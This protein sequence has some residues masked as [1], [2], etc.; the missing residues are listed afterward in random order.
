MDAFDLRLWQGFQAA[1]GN[2]AYSAIIDQITIDSRRIDSAHALFV[3]LKGEKQDGHVYVSQARAMGAKYALISKEWHPSQD[4]TPLILLRVDNPLKAFQEI[5][6]CYRNQLSSSIIGIT[7]SFGKT[8]VKDLLLSLLGT[9]KSAAASPESFNSQ[10]GVPLSLLTLRKEHQVAIIE[11]GISQRQEIDALVEIIRPDHVL[12]TPIGKKH[13]ATLEDIPTI[14][15]EMSK[16]VQRASKKG[17]KLLPDD[18][19]LSSHLNLPQESFYVWEHNSHP[20]PHASLTSHQNSYQI[21]FPDGDYFQGRIT[22]G[23]SYFLNLINMAIKAAWLEGVSSSN[24]K[25]VLADYRPE[26]TR[27][28]IWKSSQGTTFINDTYCSDPQS[29]DQALR[30]F[31]QALPQQS[32]VFVFGGMRGQS[33][34]HANDYRRIGKAIVKAGIQHLVLYGSRDFNPLM[35]EIKETLPG[36]KITLCPSYLEALEYLKDSLQSQDFILIKGDKKESLEFLTE[37][38]NDSVHNNQCLINL[39]AIRSN[40]AALKKVLDPNVR[41]M[42]MVKAFAY[43]MDDIR[44]AK[45]LATCGVD[46]LGVSYV[47]EGI[48][49]KRAGVSQAI[50][51]INA[52]FYEVIKVV[53]WSLEVGVSDKNLI[54]S[55]QIEASKQN[56]KVKVHLHVNTGM[57]RFGCRP[58]EALELAKMIKSSSHLILEGLMTH[59]ACADDPK[60][61]RFTLSQ[62]HCLNTICSSLKSHQIEPK[63]VHAANSSGAI[64]FPQAHYNMVRIG[65]AAY[66]LYVS[67][68]TKDALDLRL[69]ISLTSRI[70]GINVCLKGETISY[71]RRY[72]VEKEQQRIAVLPIGYF[73]GLHRNYSGKGYVIVHGKKAPMVGNICMDYMMIDVTDIPEAVVG[74]KVLIFGEDEFGQ[75]LSPEELA[76]SGNSIVHELITCLGPRIQRVFVYEEGRQIR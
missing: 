42:I 39:A 9:V 7:G 34:H 16:F 63:W 74:D 76:Q 73:D 33:T 10:I 60:E 23:H 71:G 1:G 20:L 2:P 48:A 40:L 19:H 22:T 15:K 29:I 58:E 44:I 70:V 62:I 17:W 61:D 21:H 67:E 72:K 24:I 25:K 57:G 28:E 5:A 8:M 69:A 30:H 13:L 41:L 59:F 32:K 65:L 11:A 46:I 6:N 27:T 75:Y 12:I 4:L 3:A 66:G 18:T 38:F 43:G 52:A 31:E 45:F 36:L 14:A 37:I 55:L 26:P 53:R 35:Q 50:F 56:K 54:E 51:S 47:D 68:A 49:L 64:R